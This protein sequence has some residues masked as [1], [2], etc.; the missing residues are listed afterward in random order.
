MPLTLDQL[1]RLDAQLAS[2]G[3]AIVEVDHESRWRH[4][5]TQPDHTG[6]LVLTE[7][8]NALHMGRGYVLVKSAVTKQLPRK[9]GQAYVSDVNGKHAWHRVVL[10]DDGDHRAWN[11]MREV[12]KAYGIPAL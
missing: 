2:E 5:Y 1:R 10:D 11:T 3:N 4:W 12:A 7:Q 8:T 9:P 6:T